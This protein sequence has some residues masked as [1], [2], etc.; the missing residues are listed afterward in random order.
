MGS[1]LFIILIPVTFS[2]N[3]FCTMIMVIMAYSVLYIRE[4][5]SHSFLGILHKFYI[6][7]AFFSSSKFYRIFCKTTFFSKLRLEISANDYSELYCN[8]NISK[9]DVPASSYADLFTLCLALSFAY[10]SVLSSSPICISYRE[11]L[12]SE[13]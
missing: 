12:H 11:K 5:S 13:P 9:I 8:L 7:P 4:S 6:F 1:I 3:P 10:Q 2:S